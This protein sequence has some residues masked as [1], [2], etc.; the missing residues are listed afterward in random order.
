MSLIWANTC[1]KYSSMYTIHHHTFLKGWSG[2]LVFTRLA[3]TRVTWITFL[4]VLAQVS[5]EVQQPKLNRP[6]EGL[7]FLNIELS[8]MGSPH[9]EAGQQS[10]LAV[11]LNRLLEKCIKDSRCVDLESLC[12]VAEEKVC[13]SYFRSDWI[14]TS[15]FSFILCNFLW[16][17]IKRFCCIMVNEQ[18]WVLKTTASTNYNDLRCLIG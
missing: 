8:P 16:L 3:Q 7:L 10:E 15:Y 14:Y 5:C 1:G 12:I 9:F 11:Q 17:F 6:N 4:R 2:V 18:Q 13:I